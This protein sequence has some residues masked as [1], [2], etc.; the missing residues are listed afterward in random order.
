MDNHLFAALPLGA[1]QAER[2]LHADVKVQVQGVEYRRVDKKIELIGFQI[3]TFLP[4]YEDSVLEHCHS[5]MLLFVTI[6][7]PNSY[8]II[9]LL[10]RLLMD[11]TET[12]N[13]IVEGQ[14]MTIPAKFA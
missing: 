12:I 14:K 3:P 8:I 7:W 10:R 6:I 2:V 9:I 11:H 4:I 5:L 13:V 1:S